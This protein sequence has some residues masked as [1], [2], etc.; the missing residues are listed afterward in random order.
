L[1]KRKTETRIYFHEDELAVTRDRVKDASGQTSDSK[2]TALLEQCKMQLGLLAKCKPGENTTNFATPQELDWQRE[3]WKTLKEIVET[4]DFERINTP[5]TG[6]AAVKLNSIYHSAVS[7]EVR[8]FAL[9]VCNMI[10]QELEQ[11]A[12]RERT[13]FSCESKSMIAQ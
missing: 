4:L 13:P 11:R 8:D 10:S 9:M 12:Y 7:S 2:K 3:D 6:E 5:H 1:T